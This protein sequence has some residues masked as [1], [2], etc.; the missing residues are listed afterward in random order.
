M[1][2]TVPTPPPP[3]FGASRAGRATPARTAAAAGATGSG[4]RSS[5][6]QQDQCTLHLASAGAH[7]Q[8]EPPCFFKLQNP[9]QLQ[10][11]PQLLSHI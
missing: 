5:M 3:F 1:V 7:M 10:W 8:A 6:Q 11:N 2:E 9:G 4:I